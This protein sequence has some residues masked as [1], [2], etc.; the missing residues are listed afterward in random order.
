MEGNVPG[1]LYAIFAIALVLSA[2]FSASEAAFLSVQRGKLA[3]MAKRGVKRA[4]RV[5]DIAGHPEKM[6]PTVLTGNNLVNTTAATVGAVIVISYLGEGTL[7]VVVATLLVTAILLIFGEILPKTLAAHYAERAAILFVGPLKI[8]ET[9][10]LPFAWGLEQLSR[11]FVRLFGVSQAKMV[12]EDEILALIDTG[13]ELGAVETHEAQMLE[14][15]FEFGDREVRQVMTPRTEIVAINQGATL[16]EFFKIYVHDPHTRFPVSK[17]TLD[18]IVGTLSTK[19]VLHAL[20]TGSL[21]PGDDVTKLLRP[22]FFVPETKKVGELFRELSNTGYQL[23]VVVD[24]FGSVAG[25]A[26]LK[27]MVEEV[28]GEVREEAVGGR[29]S[30]AIQP[31]GENIYQVEGG[32]HVKEANELLGLGIPQGGYETV[33]GFLLANLGRIPKEGDQYL[34]NGYHLEVIAMK[35]LKVQHVKISKLAAPAESPKA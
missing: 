27:E 13:R 19:E 11:W 14:R 21:K 12:T 7:A 25:L 5:A 6:L 2:F 30:D 8:A 15:V 9:V 22:A 35:G 29:R 1:F 33:A 20:A 18:V 23:V 31:L 28:V 34:H 32:L 4:S 16:E 10:L 26:T 3:S 24:E 17:D